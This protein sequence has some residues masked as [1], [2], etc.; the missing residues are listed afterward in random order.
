MPGKRFPIERSLLA[1]SAGD[2]QLFRLASLPD[3]AQ[4]YRDF[5]GGPGQLAHSRWI[6]QN[7]LARDVER[8][9]SAVRELFAFKATDRDKMPAGNS[10]DGAASRGVRHAINWNLPR[11]ATGKI[12]ENLDFIFENLEVERKAVVWSI[13]V[14]NSKFD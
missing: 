12:I 2:F 11:K 4:L 3:L 6:H 8:L 1:V 9:R 10:K 14:C 7:T 13:K 5:H